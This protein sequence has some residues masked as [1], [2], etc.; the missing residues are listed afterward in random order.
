[1]KLQRGL[2]PLPLPV[3]LE[4]APFAL[5]GVEVFQ[6]LVQE[7]AALHR[8]RARLIDEARVVVVPVEPRAFQIVVQ[9]GRA[10]MVDLNLRRVAVAPV[11]LEWLARF[12]VPEEVNVET[13]AGGALHDAIGYAGGMRRD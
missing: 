1:M 4:R 8:H 10:E 2:E 3:T 13:E 12:A 9:G 5:L 6:H 11:R 7:A